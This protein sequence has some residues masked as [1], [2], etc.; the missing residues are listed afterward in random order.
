M[1]WWKYKQLANQTA[2]LAVD[3][4][5]QWFPNE[6]RVNEKNLRSQFSA[7]MKLNA[8]ADTQA[9]QLISR[10]GP[11]LQQSNIRAEQVQYLNNGLTMNLLAQNS[12]AL[13][14]LTDQFKQ[15]GFAVE[16]GAIRN[17]GS[18]VIGMVKVQ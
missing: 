1:R 3:Q 17:Q 11:I 18:Q 6:T 13:T 15:Q 4:Y 10:V 8:N 9:L 14:R 2:Q 5:K 7:K 12:D 16:L